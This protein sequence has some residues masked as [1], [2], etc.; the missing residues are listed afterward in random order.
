MNPFTVRGRQR[1]LDAAPWSVLHADY[2]WRQTRNEFIELQ[3]RCQCCA[4]EKNLQ[5]H[6]VLPWHLFP[7][8]RYDLNN[9]LTMCQAC[10][11][12][13]GHMNNWKKFNYRILTSV[14]CIHACWPEDV[15]W[16]TF[17]RDPEFLHVLHREVRDWRAQEAE[18]P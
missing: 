2:Q 10:H 18:L 11:L 9:L 3:P 1:L 16:G 8:F 15:R 5:V 17:K 13:L 6:H 12:R 14:G 7:S 4:R